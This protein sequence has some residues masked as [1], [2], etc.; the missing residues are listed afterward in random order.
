MKGELGIIAYA[1][2]L[3]IIAIEVLSGV[4]KKFWKWII[5]V[6]TQHRECT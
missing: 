4:M 3:I 5:T 1:I 6:V 2:I